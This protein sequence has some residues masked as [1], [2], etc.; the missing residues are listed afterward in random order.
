MSDSRQGQPFRVSIVG[1]GRIGTAL[2]LQLGG[3]S[4]IEVKLVDYTEPAI[5]EA[6]RL[7]LDC[8]EGDAR[9]ATAMA[10]LLIGQHAVVAAMPASNCV[11]V[12]EV[13]SR[14]GIAYLDLCDES[15]HLDRI[16]AI[17]NA[18]GS[19]FVPQCGLSPG[20]VS[21]LVL[22]LLR[23]F[24]PTREITIRTGTLPRHA[25]NRLGYGLTWNVQSLIAEYLNPSVAVEGGAL[26]S[27]PPLSEH[28]TLRLDGRS[29]EAFVAGNVPVGLAGR[30]TRVVAKSI[31]YPGHLDLIRF[32][33]DDFK[34]AKRPDLLHTLLMNGLPDTDDDEFLIAITARTN[35][36]HRERE[37]TRFWRALP[38]RLG[39]VEVGAMRSAASSHVAAVLD[40][41]RNG[42]IAGL[43]LVAQEDLPVAALLASPFL[44]WLQQPMNGSSR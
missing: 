27:L 32:L 37:T 42:E 41:L 43:G 36:Q 34:L 31:R 13:A 6:N 22:E 5:A 20:L 1:A 8:L 25:T 11:Q 40:L 26:T 18:A 35:H 15:T 17:A 33:I 3:K 44:G 14:L 28:E 23:E 29:Y 4:G 19:L 10:Q 39:G 16:R 21:T 7:G 38:A 12:A 9:D 2:A 30:A 24:G